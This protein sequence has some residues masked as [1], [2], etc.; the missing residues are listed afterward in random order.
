MSSRTVAL[1]LCMA[2][3]A[4]APA[5]ARDAYRIETVAEG[6][7]YPWSLAFLPG[8]D[9]LVTERVGRLRLIR[10]GRLQPAP[11]EGVPGDIHVGRQT[12]LMEVALDPRFEEN[13]FV[14]LTH[15]YGTTPANNTR[16]V[17]ARWDGERLHGARVLFDALPAKAGDSHYGGR[18]AFLPDETLVL[19]LGD[20]FVLREEAQNPANHLGKLVR[21]TRDGA[22][23]GD[24]PFADRSDAAREIYSLGHRNVQG[25]AVVDG[26]VWASEH[27]PRG[28]D[29]LN[30]IVPGA[31]YGWPLVTHGVDYTWAR[32]SPYTELPG[33][34][35]PVVQ[36]TPSIAPAGLLHYT[37]GLFPQWRGDFFL[38]TLAEKSVRRV[39]LRDGAEAGQEV[40]F[41]EL[42]ARIRDVRQAPDGALWLLTD[43]EAGRVL[44]V[45]PVAGEANEEE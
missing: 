21:L 4:F 19:T 27:G 5:Q 35:Q 13:G 24:N 29:E 12:G 28:G 25:I 31:N 43:E 32:I 10:D 15:A 1:L 30:R 40:L 45:V 41:A 42:G 38:P 17:R 44:R 3:L 14:Y 36:W 16:L 7:E 22:V 37:G 34:E 2:C 33:M 23:P 18:I 8:G 11:V 39:R 9:V 20:A 6:L 26:Q